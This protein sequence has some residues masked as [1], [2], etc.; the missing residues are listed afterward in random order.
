MRSLLFTVLRNNLLQQSVKTQ[1]CNWTNS[2][3]CTTRDIST[4]LYPL[5][6]G[7]S[8]WANIRHIKAAK[9]GQKSALFS[10]IARQIRLAIQDGGSADPN[11]NSELKSVIEEALRKNMPMATIQNNLKKFTA[12]KT[13][14]K[15]YRQDVRF[16]QKV[17]M[18]CTIYTDNF[19]QL[20]MDMSTI[21]RKGGGVQIDAGHL[22]EDFGLIQA[23]ADKTRLA[24]GESLE[25]KA[26]E[27]AIESGAEDIEV[28]DNESG[29][30]HFICKP[31][32][33]NG[34]RKA[35][36]N[37]GYVVNN[38]EHIFTPLNT[39]TLT[40]EEK[41]DYQKFVDKLKEIQGIEDIYDNIEVDEAE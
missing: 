4:Q 9:D 25:D 41:A 35:L 2:L 15:K 39:V 8:K 17:F 13:Q 6:A 18:V 24:A 31:E 29:S 38:T 27:D 14:L 23:T 10:R 20:K 21:L 11:L 16:K 37:K 30:V 7:H 12:S 3:S 19:A 32:G 33:I 26:T 1:T 36:E 40:P 34:V 5:L 28:I 22:F